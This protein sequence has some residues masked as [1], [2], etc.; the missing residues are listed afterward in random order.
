MTIA[1]CL[2]LPEGVIFAADSTSSAECSDGMHFYHHHQKVF[3][4]GHGSQV[5]AVAWGVSAFGETSVRTL[6]ARLGDEIGAG[7]SMRQLATRL[8][9]TSFEAYQEGFE[10]QIAKLQSFQSRH[11]GVR[12]PAEDKEMKDI[13]DGLRWGVCIGGCSNDRNPEAYWFEIDAGLRSPSVVL[14]VDHYQF[15][16]QKHIADRVFDRVDHNLYE[17]IL[18]SG[19]WKGTSNELHKIMY[20]ST[21]DPPGM[22]IRD[23]IDFAHF[24]IYST[25]KM[26]KFSELLQTCGGPIELAVITTDRPFRWV[27]HKDMDAAISSGL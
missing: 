27:I 3:E 5:G 23:G 19:K 16:G 15:F 18:K 13:V 24:G 14:H 1:S 17:A 21:T 7:A 6:L 9:T 10:R 22:N 11:D 25:I 2:V 20:D 4:V 8:A 26:L 12:S